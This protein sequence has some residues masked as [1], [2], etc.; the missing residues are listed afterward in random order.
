VQAITDGT[1]AGASSDAAKASGELMEALKAKAQEQP[2]Q[3]EPPHPAESGEAPPENITDS[4]PDVDN[5]PPPVTAEEI[6]GLK[7]T[8][9][10]PTTKPGPRRV[11]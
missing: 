8:D 10:P 4:K 5:A 11:K 1:M 7:P 9:P 3:Q 2:S 6:F